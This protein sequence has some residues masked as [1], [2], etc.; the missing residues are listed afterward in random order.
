MV[1]SRI[2]GP[3]REPTRR[4]LYQGRGRGSPFI[5]WPFDESDM[6][7]IPRSNSRVTTPS[8]LR[9]PVSMC[10]RACMYVYWSA[11]VISGLANVR[12]RIHVHLKARWCKDAYISLDMRV[13]T[14]TR[15]YEIRRTTHAQRVCVK[16]GAP[17]SI[18]G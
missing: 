10:A 11:Y 2:T 3:K 14:Y 16:D 8:A 4:V 18:T 5:F 1:N 7:S 12:S 13:Y 17:R 6:P 15:A 9:S